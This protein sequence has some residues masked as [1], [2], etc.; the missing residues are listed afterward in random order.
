M[1]VNNLVIDMRNVKFQA[2]QAATF[3]IDGP[4]R[5]YIYALGGLT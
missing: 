1:P 4:C 5:E 3:I 2:S